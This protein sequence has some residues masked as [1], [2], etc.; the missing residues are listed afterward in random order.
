MM[1]YLPSF[2]IALIAYCACDSFC[3]AISTT[4]NMNPAE[5]T[6][7]AMAQS[8]TFQVADSAAV[9]TNFHTINPL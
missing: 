7:D 5:E 2:L 1:K 4:D 6:R 3:R 8:A 9:V